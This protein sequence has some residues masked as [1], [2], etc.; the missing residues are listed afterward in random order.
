MCAG[1][2]WSSAEAFI[3]S[4]TCLIWSPLG[5]K[6]AGCNTQVAVLTRFSLIFIDTRVNSANVHFC[7][8]GII[9]TACIIIIGIPIVLKLDM[10]IGWQFSM[11][12]D[13][14]L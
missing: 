2:S 12:T 14:F 11:A 6:L 7:T 3:Y 8:W 5:D 10:A 1:R 13:G 9:F 4:G